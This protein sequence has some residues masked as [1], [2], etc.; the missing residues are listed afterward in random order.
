[1]S[2]FATP[3]PIIKAAF[4]RIESGLKLGFW[5]GSVLYGAFLA[6]HQRG[7]GELEAVIEALA[8]R[9]WSWPWFDQMAVAF[10]LIG[11]WPNSWKEHEIAPPPA[12]NDI[13]DVVRCSLLARTLLAATYVTRDRA[14]LVD[15]TKGTGLKLLLVVGDDQCPAEAHFVKLHKAAIQRGQH[16]NLPPYFPGDSSHLRVHRGAEDEARPT[17]RRRPS[18]PG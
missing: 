4:D 3:K 18:K 11:F 7:D 9:K 17:T 8:G 14:N 1:M 5:R 13:P 12:W 16:A 6:A 10:N 2:D 15:A